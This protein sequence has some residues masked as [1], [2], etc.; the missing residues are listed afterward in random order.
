MKKSALA[1]AVAFAAS[2]GFTSAAYADAQYKVNATFVQGSTTEVVNAE[3]TVSGGKVTGATGSV[4]GSGFTGPNADLN[5]VQNITQFLDNPNFPGT[6]SIR[7]VSTGTDLIFDNI[8]STGSL[9]DNGIVFQVADG[10]YMNLWENSPGNFALFL[11]WPVFADLSA[12]GTL[13]VPEPSALAMMLTALL[14]L[15]G[16]FFLRH[17]ANVRAFAAI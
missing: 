7:I 13:Q 12:S 3:L 15:G 2:V 11:D 10:T 4:D 14:A 17:R 5:G 16:V 6:D 8:F 1:F 9:S